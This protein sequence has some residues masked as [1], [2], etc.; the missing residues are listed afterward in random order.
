[1]GRD[2]PTN[3]P[4]GY[5]ALSN[6]NISTNGMTENEFGQQIQ[7]VVADYLELWASNI[8]SAGV[9]IS[10]LYTHTTFVTLD[11]YLSMVATKQAP[12]DSYPYVVN[13]YNSTTDPKTAL[14][15]NFWPGYTVYPT[16]DVFETIHV[17]TEA[18]GPWALSEGTNYNPPGPLGDTGMTMYEYLNNA[19][20]YGATLVNI[21]GFNVGISNYQTTTQSPDALSAYRAFLQGVA[22]ND[23]NMLKE[24]FV[25]FLEILIIQFFMF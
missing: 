22:F 1:M 3:L 13:T 20:G 19:Y 2:Y 5:R 10:K 16:T 11:Q 17:V 25:L 9:P 7:L 18:T 23:T 8:V 4:N 12:A 15:T 21:F 14:G 6:L 24:Y